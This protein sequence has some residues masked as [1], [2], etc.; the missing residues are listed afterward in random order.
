MMLLS[1]SGMELL[2]VSAAYSGSSMC[3]QSLFSPLT[4]AF[5]AAG[6]AAALASSS[7]CCCYC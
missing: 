2:R 4:A 7:L 3:A 1:S 6:A 5:A